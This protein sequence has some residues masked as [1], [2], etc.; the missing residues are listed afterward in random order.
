MTR[1]DRNDLW[2]V[3][4]IYGVGGH[5]LERIKLLYKDECLCVSE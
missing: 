1:T 5:L 2:N 4:W 3:L